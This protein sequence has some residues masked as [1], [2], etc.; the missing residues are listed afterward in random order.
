MKWIKLF[1]SFERDEDYIV[2]SIRDI[3]IELQD[4][5]MEIEIDYRPEDFKYDRKSYALEEPKKTIIQPSV[6]I[7]IKGKNVNDYPY[8]MHK[9]FEVSSIRDYVDTVID[10]IEDIWPSYTLYFEKYDVD[11]SHLFDGEILQ[12]GPV[13][14]IVIQI[15]KREI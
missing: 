5:G 4:E 1:E 6:T 8:E 7:E 2:S 12:D 15:H 13:G 3:L 10:F 11:D 14:L 9:E